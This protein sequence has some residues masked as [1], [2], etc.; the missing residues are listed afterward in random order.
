MKHRAPPRL[1]TWLLAAFLRQRDKEML[2]GDLVEEYALRASGGRSIEASRWYWA[3][4]L[5]SAGPLLWSNIRRGNW[6]R[7]L[8]A[9]LAGY[10]LVALLVIAGDVAMSKLLPPGELAYSL[11]SLAAGLSAM[12]LGG[13]IAAGMRQ[14][15][16]IGLA[17]IAAVMGVVSLVVTGDRA[18][19][20]YQIALI[21]LGPAAALA[22]GRIRVRKKGAARA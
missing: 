10:L 7:T 6:W 4:V 12:V 22:G 9:A 2:L 16:A 1:A 5:H 13:Y 11:L 3:Q 15:A 18:P 21:V 19:L 8:A 20:W 17:V 14:R